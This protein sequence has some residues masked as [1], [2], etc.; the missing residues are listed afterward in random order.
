MVEV[1]GRSLSCRRGGLGLRWSGEALLE[2]V[3]SRKECR[4]G[5]DKHGSDLAEQRQVRLFEDTL[6]RLGYRATLR[7][8]PSE[9]LYFDYINDSRN[10]AQIGPAGWSSDYPS[11]TG[12]LGPIF[13]CA[14][15][16]SGQANVAH[17]C[18][19]RMDRLLARA[20][21]L[22][23]ADVRAEALL[24]AADRRLVDQAASV[25]LVNPRAVALVSRR[26]GN[27]WYSQQWGVLYDQLWVR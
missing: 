2:H 14:S 9:D 18:D 19:R 17:F 6:E 20:E 7:V 25:P 23:G 24:A 1:A 3:S 15:G 22:P 11:G 26:V 10:R 16:T 12:F 5:G 13:T 21:R 8:F 4:T 27:Y